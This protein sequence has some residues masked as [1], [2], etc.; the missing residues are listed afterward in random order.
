MLHPVLRLETW[1]RTRV[2]WLC[3]VMLHHLSTGA[4]DAALCGVMRAQCVSFVFL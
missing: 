4:G 2:G 1:N 3:A